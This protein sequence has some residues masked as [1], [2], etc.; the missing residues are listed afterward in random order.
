MLTLLGELI[1]NPRERSHI[2]R[3]LLEAAGGDGIL[4]GSIS[5]SVSLYSADG[6]LC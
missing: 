6:R 4:R 2:V 5:G 1:V 3:L